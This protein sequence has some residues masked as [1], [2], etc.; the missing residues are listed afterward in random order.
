MIRRAAGREKKS[1][2]KLTS[3]VRTAQA[4][5]AAG[6]PR[7]KILRMNFDRYAG[8]ASAV[9]IVLILT[10]VNWLGFWGPIWHSDWK[11]QPSDWLGLGGALFGSFCTI[12]AGGWA[13]YGVRQQ[14]KITQGQI[15]V[16][17]KEARANQ[18]KSLDDDVK[19]LGEDIDRLILAKGF[20]AKFVEAFPDSGNLDGFTMR[21]VHSRNDALDFVSQSAVTAPFGYGEIVSTLMSRIQRL[22]DRIDEKS[23]GYAPEQ[24]IKDYYEP[25]VREAILGIRSVVV[26][27][28]YQIPIRQRELIRLSDERDRF[29]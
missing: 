9:G 10:L 2:L 12:A 25:R 16:A 3:L 20:L 4:A 15:E 26:Q 24:G 23:K 28:E 7:Q 21:L 18:F 22:G 6:R 1:R 11:S 29:A 13:Y 5:S 14:I 27:I 19:K 8:M 17:Q